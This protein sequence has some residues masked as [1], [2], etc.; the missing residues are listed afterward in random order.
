[1]KHRHRSR[2]RV[3]EMLL[4]IKKEK[5]ACDS[6]K[7]TNPAD[8][9]PGYSG[10]IASLL[11][12]AQLFMFSGCGNEQPVAVDNPAVQIPNPISV[13]FVELPDVAD[14]V[15]RLW[16]AE[17]SG[18]L[19][20]KDVTSDE[21]FDPDYFA[22]ADHDIIVYPGHLLGQ[23]IADGKISNLPN[24][25]WDSP[26]L[27]NRSL[28]RH[29]RTTLVRF[30]KQRWAVPIGNPQF[31][32]LIR[33]DVLKAAGLQ[34][35][36]TWSELVA[37]KIGL[38]DQKNLLADDGK[39]LPI[40]I[41]LPSTQG[42][43]A[44]S[45]LVMAASRIR[46]RGILNSLFDRRTMQPL[47]D[48]EPYIET[49]KELK[50]LTG[51][52]TPLDPAGV[53]ESFFSGGS[54]IA[55]GWPNRAFL[56][57]GADDDFTQ[58][59]DNVSIHR[60]PG[61]SRWFDFAND[62]WQQVDGPVERVE[63]IGFDSRLASILDS[64]SHPTEAYEFL[65]WLASKQVGNSIFAG[66]RFGAPT[67]TSH[68]GIAQNWTGEVF[69]QVVSDVFSD[70]FLEIN[71]EP[72]FLMFPQIPGSHRYWDALEDSIQQFL[73]GEIEAQPALEAVALQWNKITDDLDRQQ[74]IEWLRKDQGY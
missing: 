27:D 51:G 61:S 71:E 6:M 57:E 72:V 20:T 12:V 5:V 7:I 10:I 44:K 26:Q 62:S 40:E 54:A 32:M 53:I 73:A 55:M 37:L 23:L 30:G 13:V 50:L 31:F 64:A 39:P 2:Q 16:S 60:V 4:I 48:R 1:M 58:M 52:T 47:I 43:A 38:A 24:D 70:L 42:W 74:Q 34:L 14:A 11:F 36:K 29:N 66:S 46:H 33:N 8:R 41:T 22:I 3:E 25:V 28:L 63:L 65:A 9:I 59:Y 15:S 19:T 67:R 49:L 17:R 68:L 18:I 45:F 56:P 35:P 69:N 21:L